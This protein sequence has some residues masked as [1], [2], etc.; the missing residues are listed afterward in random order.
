[1]TSLALPGEDEARRGKRSGRKKSSTV[2]VATRRFFRAPQAGRGGLPPMKSARH[3]DPYRLTCRGD[4]WSPFFSS[5][6]LPP[7]PREVA[8]LCRDGR[9]DSLSRRGDSSLME[10]AVITTGAFF[11][12]SAAR[13]RSP[14]WAHLSPPFPGTPKN[15]F[16]VFGEPLFSPPCPPPSPRKSSGL[17][18]YRAGSCS[19]RYDKKF[20]C[21]TDI[22][23]IHRKRSPFPNRGRQ[24]TSRCPLI[25]RMMGGDRG[26]WGV[27]G[28]AELE[29]WGP[30]I[31]R[32]EGTPYLFTIH[33]SLFTREG[34]PLPYNGRPTVGRPTSGVC[35]PHQSCDMMGGGRGG[36]G[37]ARGVDGML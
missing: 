2:A 24:E 28:E 15:S 18:T 11:A 17:S 37:G 34:R 36:L 13:V 3:K 8:Q 12:V 21:V 27:L 5:P 33:Y 1:M 29:G 20:I 25:R 7:S 16:L 22:R 35:P 23:L 31:I 26:V 6:F 14:R 30:T 19:R 10:G 4:R 32:P 9:S